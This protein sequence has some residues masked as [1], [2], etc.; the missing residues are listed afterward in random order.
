MNFK[1]DNRSLRLSDDPDRDVRW[2]VAI[3]K[4]T[5][6]DT[7]HKLSDDPSEYVRLAAQQRLSELKG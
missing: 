2:R 5:H 4:N 6:Q 7:L 3:H 1:T